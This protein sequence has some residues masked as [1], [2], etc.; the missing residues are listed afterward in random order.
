MPTYV[1]INHVSLD[2]EKLGLD[3]LRTHYSGWVTYDIHH[4]LERY[5]EELLLK[6]LNGLSAIIPKLYKRELGDME[7]PEKEVFKD[8]DHHGLF[9]MIMEDFIHL[10]HIPVSDFC[11]IVPGT[12]KLPGDQDSSSASAAAERSDASTA[13]TNSS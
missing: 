1:N 5:H 12:Y 3:F 4:W 8:V 11:F 13:P 6:P 10:E 9:E 2:R 7:G